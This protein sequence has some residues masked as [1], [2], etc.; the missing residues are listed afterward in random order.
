[1]TRVIYW[2]W[3]VTA[4]VALVT[5]VTAEPVT[6]P[7]PLPLLLTFDDGPDP[8]WTARVLDVLAWKHAHAVFCMTGEHAAAHPE[9]VRR[10]VAEGHVLCAHSWDHP[11]LPQLSAADQRGEVSRSIGTLQ[12]YAIVRW[13]RPP[14][15]QSDAGILGYAVH[16][17]A[18]D[19]GLGWE[20]DASDWSAGITPAQVSSL[21]DAG[22]AAPVQKATTALSPSGV[23]TVLLH[24]GHGEDHADVG[25]DRWPGAAALV[26]LLDRYAIA[27]PAHLPG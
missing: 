19:G 9:L 3:L 13:F 6:S 1:M 5:V 26:D 14:Y 21:L 27:D 7:S 17:G 18:T 8:I 10:V 24:D 16:C 11:H 23:I 20:V 2:S 22:I 25:A 4:I 12:P 15:G